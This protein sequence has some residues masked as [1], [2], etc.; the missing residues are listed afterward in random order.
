MYIKPL[1][2]NIAT[3][4]ICIKYRYLLFSY[5]KM[6]L[7]DEKI[8]GRNYISLIYICKFET[9]SKTGIYTHINIYIIYDIYNL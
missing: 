2:K 9:F 4:K 8:K 7:F 5:Q 6:S 3:F 1:L